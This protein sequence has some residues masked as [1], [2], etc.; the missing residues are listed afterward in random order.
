[1]AENLNPTNP[2]TKEPAATEAAPFPATINESARVSARHPIIDKIL[3][4]MNVTFWHV[5][6]LVIILFAIQVKKFNL[7]SDIS[8]TIT[9]LPYLIAGLG[10]IFLGKGRY[11][12]RNDYMAAYKKDRQFPHYWKVPLLTG[13]FFILL[14]SGLYALAVGV[15]LV[16]RVHNPMMLT[17]FLIIFSLYFLWYFIAHLS[18]RF[19]TLASVRVSL[20]SL[21][22]AAIAFFLWVSREMVLVSIVFALF[23]VITLLVSLYLAAT[24]KLQLGAWPRFAC[25]AATVMFLLPVALN[26]FAFGKPH[27]SHVGLELAC[28]GIEGK[29][30]A[31]AYSQD[32]Q[33][34][35]FCQKTSDS[36]YLQVVNLKDKNAVFKI[37]AGEDVFKPIFID[38]GKYIL[39]DVLK[40]GN[41]ELWKVDA[42]NGSTAILKTGIQSIENG[43]PW[44]E[45][46]RKFLFVRAMENGSTLNVM[47]L[48]TLQSKELMHLNSPIHTPSWSFSGDKVL[49]ADGVS[50]LPYTYDVSTAVLEPVISSRDRP[51]MAN[52][53]KGPAVIEILPAPDGFRYLYLT[54]KDKVYSFWEVRPD[55][56]N[57]EN[58]YETK[59][60]SVRNITWFPN[61]QRFIFEEKMRR[62][63][64]H[65]ETD[66]VILVDAN[67]GTVETLLP[68]QISTR[69]PSISPAGVNIAFTG[70]TGLWYP[71]F[72]KLI[73]PFDEK[74]GVWVARLR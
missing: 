59:A 73:P 27:S 69:S 68:T 74:T 26:A 28:S 11:M 3:K 35:G 8:K 62:N 14:L 22:L 47:D 32:G 31:S 50:G 24:S 49:F 58:I 34:I 61:G 43:T 37:N 46:N 19:T 4:Y 44:F 45:K 51:E 60:S 7:F 52:L 10:L 12:V 48:M 71:S 65:S 42:S 70:T 1:V 15:N 13:Q 63:D 54:L 72:Q 29:V 67:L 23:A 20:L 17:F 30:L 9:H 53:L 41:R 66:N 6:G 36:V 39:I 16:D 38:N 33:K 21:F 25:L 64:F 40:G 18:N 5:L 2:D 57:R 56:T 55:G